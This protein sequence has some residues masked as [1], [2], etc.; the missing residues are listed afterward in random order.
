MANHPVAVVAE[1]PAQFSSDV[2]V[3]NAE[4][5]TIDLSLMDSTNLA[6]P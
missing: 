6:A 1:H 5:F 2:I 4:T 3:V